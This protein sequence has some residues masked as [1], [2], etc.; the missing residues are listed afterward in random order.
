MDSSI[1]VASIGSLTTIV[2]AFL[3][4]FRKAKPRGSTSAAS[5][6]GEALPRSRFLLVLVLGLSITANAVLFALVKPWS[7]PTIV[8]SQQKTSTPPSIKLEA[9]VKASGDIIDITCPPGTY[10]N[11]ISFRIDKGG[12]HGIISNITPKFEPLPIK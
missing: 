12:P 7:T 9:T 6:A 3:E 1:I 4:K 11:G 10:M 5:R 2:L 8:E